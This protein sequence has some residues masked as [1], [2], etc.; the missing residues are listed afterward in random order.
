MTRSEPSGA[1]TQRQ[2]S[3]PPVDRVRAIAQILADEAEAAETQGALTTKSIEALRS[4]G[5]FHLWLPRCLGGDET[6]PLEA[7]EALELICHADASTGWVAMASQLC[8][9][10][11]AAY[12]SPSA[13]K[14]IFSGDAVIIGGQGAP[15]G[16]AV[17]SEDGYQ[18]S[19]HWSYG[20]GI[21]HAD[22]LHTGGYVYRDGKLE[23]NPE[24]SA[25]DSMIFIVPK[26]EATLLSNW[27]TLGLRA[28]GSVDYSLTNTF[29]HRE[30]THKLTANI[31]N[32]GGDLYRL[33]VPGFSAI[34]HTAFA[35]GVGR[36]ILDELSA[37]TKGDK[38]P[39]YMTGSAAENF[40]L[41]YGDAEAKLRSVRALAYEVWTDI[42]KTLE[43]GSDLSIRQGTLMRLVV[44]HA[45]STSAELAQFAFRFAGGR[46]T[47]NGA[48]QRCFRDMQTGAQHGTAS[49]PVLAE[50][51]RELLH[52]AAGKRWGF[53]NLISGPSN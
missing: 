29:V 14:E 20:S 23:T 7:L 12:L 1:F 34:G 3:M 19:G 33:A 38:Q 36:R 42:E 10:T 25:P 11:A 51:S 15:N 46:A 5:I 37:V 41:H 49:P 28:T 18:L 6:F 27:D 21:Q 9:A 40:L 31:P 48:L 32:Q 39:T 53:R 44:N 24:T 16:Q 43:K 8:S 4:A 35:L 2:K 17:P 30:Y 22:Y 26:L 45:T 50:C 52:Q 13:A 47:R